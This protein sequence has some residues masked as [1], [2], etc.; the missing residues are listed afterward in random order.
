[1]TAVLVIETE[2]ERKKVKD[3]FDGLEF[4]YTVV[5]HVRSVQ[6]LEG[7]RFTQVWYTPDVMIHG[8]DRD[9]FD[10][11]YRTLVSSSIKF[12]AQGFRLLG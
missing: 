2:A 11:L 6:M 4:D 10:R 9:L 1:M 5:N 3:F 12:P 8:M 7:L